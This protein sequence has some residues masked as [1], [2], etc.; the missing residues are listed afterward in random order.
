[1]AVLAHLCSKEALGRDVVAQRSKVGGGR[2]KLDGEVVIFVEY[3]RSHI[4]RPCLQEQDNVQQEHLA[5]GRPSDPAV[6]GK[7][8]RWGAHTSPPLHRWCRGCKVKV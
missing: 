8:T 5:R 1:M 4:A 2:H 7:D 3:C 6:L